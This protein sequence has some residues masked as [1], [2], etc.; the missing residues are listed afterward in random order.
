MLVNITDYKIIARNVQYKSRGPFYV[1]TYQQKDQTA[2]TVIA[3]LNSQHF[4]QIFYLFLKEY[5]IS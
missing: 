2:S 4:L 3:K 5:T 1:L